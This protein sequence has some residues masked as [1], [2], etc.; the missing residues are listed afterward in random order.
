MSKTRKLLGA[1]A[2]AGVLAAGGA[3]FTAGNSLPSP[4]VTKGY[5]S[6][7]ISGVSA[8]SIAYNTNVPKDTITSVGLVLTGDTTA[9]TIQIA[10][11]DAAPATCSD[12]G[13]FDAGSDHTTYACD[14][15]QSVVTAAKF[16]LIAE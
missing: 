6:Q 4:T 11:D 12:A 5:G 7:T 15:T 2:L 14:V 8:E 9:K 1:T 3:A 13:A 10:F 16:A